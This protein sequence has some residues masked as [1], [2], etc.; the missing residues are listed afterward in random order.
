MRIFKTAVRARNRFSR[1]IFI[2]CIFAVACTS[3]LKL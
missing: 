3:Y 2:N 1:Y